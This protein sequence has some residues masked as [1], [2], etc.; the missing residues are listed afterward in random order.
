MCVCVYVCTMCMQCMQ[1]RHVMYVY[2]YECINT[3]IL[4]SLSTILTYLHAHHT[5]CTQR[6]AQQTS[7]ILRPCFLLAYLFGGRLEDRHTYRRV[8]T[9][10]KHNSAHTCATTHKHGKPAGSCCR[11]L[12]EGCGRCGTVKML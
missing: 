6:E 8:V 10:Y 9:R 5:I 12:P 7:T 3:D 2:V 11:L 1:C 4:T